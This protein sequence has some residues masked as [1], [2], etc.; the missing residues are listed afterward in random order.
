MDLQLM[1]PAAQKTGDHPRQL[2]QQPQLL[3]PGVALTLTM[4]VDR[5]LVEG[6]LR[7]RSKLGTLSPSFPWGEWAYLP[8]A[9]KR[10]DF[11]RVC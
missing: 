11:R 3:L 6:V 4:T 9:N 5:F 1:D 8:Q 7:A 2:A 10:K